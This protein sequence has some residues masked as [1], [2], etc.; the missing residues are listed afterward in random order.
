M[1]SQVKVS[2]VAALG[3]S[4]IAW[5]EAAHNPPEAKAAQCV[6]AFVPLLG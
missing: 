5:A 1:K 6:R 2:V 3:L 4:A